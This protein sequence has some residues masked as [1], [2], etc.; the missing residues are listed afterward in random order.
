MKVT[1][2]VAGEFYAKSASNRELFQNPWLSPE[3]A[4]GMYGA[5][6]GMER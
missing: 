4:S 3:A 5:E 1:A 2:K 6:S